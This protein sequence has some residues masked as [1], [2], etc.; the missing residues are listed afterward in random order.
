MAIGNQKGPDDKPVDRLI[1]VTGATGQ[2]GRLIVERLKQQVPTGRVVA[3]AR[4]IEKAGGLGVATREADYERLDTLG[5]ALAG[6]ETLLLISASES[7][8]RL[9]QHRNVIQAAKQA[10]VKWIVYTSLL[11]TDRSPLKLAAEHIGT[12]REIEASGIPFTILRNGWYTENYT[13]GLVGALASG[14]IVGSA[15]EGRVSAAT[16]A[17]FADAAVAVLT[18]GPADHAGKVYELAGD[19]AFT[20]AELAAEVSR[21]AGKPMVYRDVPEAEYATMLTGYGLPEPFARVIADADVGVSRGDLF[22]DSR[23][24]SRLIDRPTTPMSTAVSNALRTQAS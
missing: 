3:L 14:A 12:E 13:A 18:G 24:L 2:L 9:A 1:A 23:Q 10:G 7:G 16:R 20:M 11:R 5:P 19:S 17:D 15:G 6:V 21:Q 22:D 8:K 4:S